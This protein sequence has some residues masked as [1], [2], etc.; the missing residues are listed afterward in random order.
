MKM[1][2]IDIKKDIHINASK[3]LVW[4]ISYDKF[5]EVDKWLT[6]VPVSTGSNPKQENDISC[7]RQCTPNVKGFSKTK[8][9]LEYVNADKGVLR[10]RV[11]KGLPGFVKSATNEWTLT[12]TTNGTSLHMNMQMELKGVLGFLMGGIMKRQMP[13]VLQ[14]ALEDLKH[15]SEHGEPHPR[16]IKATNKW[17]SKNPRKAA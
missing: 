15:F 4:G 16:K 13:N 8:E 14:E 11:I 2:R 5:S 9:V 7:E 10:Y 17:A 12:E 6:A 1:S 3:S